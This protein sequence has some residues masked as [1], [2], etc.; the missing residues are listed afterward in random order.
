MAL[1]P[2]QRKVLRAFTRA[3]RD[4][5]ATRKPTKALIE[6]G[7]TESNLRNLSYGDRDS[8]GSLQQRPS[9]G[10]QNARDPYKAAV[11]F[12]KQ[13]IPI[14]G[15]YGTAGQLAQAV[16][17]SAYPGRYDQRSGQ[18]NALL[19]GSQANGP[20]LG[21][22]AAKQSS[23]GSD[24]TQI[25]LSLLGMGS[26]SGDYGGGSDPLTLALIQAAQ[27][28]KAPSRSGPSS[29]GPSPRTG[30][31]VGHPLDRPGVHTR[32][33]I[34]DFVSHVAS[35]YGKPIRL[36]TGTAHNRLTVNG[37]VSAHWEGNAL[38]LPSAG[39]QNL[40]LGRAAL[41]AAG[42]PPKQ[43][44]KAKGGIYN[45]GGYQIIF[46]TDQGGNHFNHVHVGLRG[47]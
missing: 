33:P 16:Q 39:K 29:Y 8:L 28:G 24:R 35:V 40:A 1:T 45:I 27:Q 26:L 32:K 47:T 42:M 3:S 7:L 22:G 41:V 36:G 4:L 11:D 30:R 18:A 10:W 12:L 2:E 38:D 9:Q 37:N 46:Q 6:A 13:A 19:R 20:N 31:T 23:L 43:A 25:A 34:L 17:R 14:K 44:A 5:G 21:Y 15:K